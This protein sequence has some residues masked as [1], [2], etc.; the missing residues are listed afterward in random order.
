VVYAPPPR[1][2]VW[3]LLT[4]DMFLDQGRNV[5]R[6]R[7]VTANVFIRRPVF[8][9]LGGFDPTLPSGGDY[10]FVRRAVANGARLAHAPGAVVRH[11]TLDSFGAFVRKVFT[12]SRWA[13]ARRART[14]QGIK[15][16]S[17]LTLMPVVNTVQ[18]RRYARRPAW[19][20]G[21]GQLEASGVAPRR[22]DQLRALA[23]LYVVVPYVSAFARLR[24][25]WDGRRLIHD[26]PTGSP[27]P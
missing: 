27:S 22:M 18:A 14:G 1:P 11:P 24:G 9:A 6:S 8:E 3:S 23:A 16:S 15:A 19:R 2:T 5:T 7:A 20:L 13:A 21:R 4:I 10:D 25:T 12:T 26:R 17:A